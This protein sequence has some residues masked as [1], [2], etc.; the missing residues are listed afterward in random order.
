MNIDKIDEAENLI[1]KFRRVQN[2]KES[3]VEI[4]CEDG[5]DTDSF[6]LLEQDSVFSICLDGLK[7]EVIEAIEGVLNYQYDK[8]TARLRDI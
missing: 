3:I 6:V 5:I 2:A 7:T 8:I 1:K 4:N